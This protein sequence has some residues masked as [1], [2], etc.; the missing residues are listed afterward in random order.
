MKTAFAVF[1]GGMFKKADSA[2]I[3][4]TPGVATFSN[5]AGDSGG[6]AAF[7]NAAAR[8]SAA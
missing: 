4:F 2:S 5:G 8:C 7:R 3:V 1:S 6:A